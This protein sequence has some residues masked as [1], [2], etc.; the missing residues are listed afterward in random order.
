MTGEKGLERATAF[1]KKLGSPD[2]G[3]EILHRLAKVFKDQGRYELAKKTY[4][5]VMRLNP[6]Y[7]KMPNVEFELLSAMEHDA[8]P[9]ESNSR[10]VDFFNKYNSRSSWAGKQSDPDAIACA[11]SLTQ[12][13]LYDA[14][15]GYHQ[16]ALQKN[17]TTSY[18]LAI[19]VY[20][21]FTRAYP[22]AKLASE[23]YYNLAEI[24][25]SKGDYIKATEDFIT[26]SKRYPDSKFRE[27]AAWNAIVSSQNLL[28]S[29]NPLR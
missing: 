23:C 24:E 1:A 27:T 28:K 2:R 18:N 15:I 5:L 17:D 6:N 3:S 11:D 10:K 12:K 29:E 7:P 20:T 14:A 26:V 8:T 22:K 25:F 21:D 13:Q 16:M 4:R 9:E 19:S